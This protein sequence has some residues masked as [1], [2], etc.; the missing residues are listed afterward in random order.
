MFGTTEEVKF[1]LIVT[2]NDL[3]SLRKNDKCEAFLSFNC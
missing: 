3:E 1:N 2:T